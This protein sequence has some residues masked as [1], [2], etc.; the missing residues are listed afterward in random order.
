MLTKSWQDH[1]M[2]TLLGLIDQLQGRFERRLPRAHF[3]SLLIALRVFFSSN[4]DGEHGTRD[5]VVGPLSTNNSSVVWHKKTNNASA[6]HPHSNTLC[7]PSSA[8]NQ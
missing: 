6:A 5:E 1:T 2:I 7:V 8:T 3:F 4:M